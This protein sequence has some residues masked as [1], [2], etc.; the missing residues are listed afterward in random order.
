MIRFILFITTAFFAFSTHA[1]DC[2]QF[3]VVKGKVSFKKKSKSKF[4]KARINKKV[5]QG[6]VV[7]TG[8][9]SRAKIIMADTNEINI[10]PKTEL[11]IE[12]YQKNKKAVLNVLNGKVRSNVKRKYK[13]NANSHYR[14]KTKSAVAGVRGTEFLASYNSATNQSRVVTFEGEVMVGRIDAS[15]AVGNRVSV[16]PGQFITNSVG[17]DPHPP[18]EVPKAELARMDQDSNL[19]EVPDRGNASD[20]KPANENTTDDKKSDADAKPSEEPKAEKNEPKADSEAKEQNRDS[21]KKEERQAK[22]ERREQAKEER[23][24]RREAQREEKRERRE[25]AKEE[26]QQRREAQRE[27]KQERR[28]ARREARQERREARRDRRQQRRGSNGNGR[29]I[30]SVGPRDAAG[31]IPVVDSPDTAGGTSADLPVSDP[32]ALLPPPTLD[33][34]IGN[35]SDTDIRP[36]TIFVPP[37]VPIDNICQTCND[38]VINQKVRVTIRPCVA[39]TCNN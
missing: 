36:P 35:I 23:R 8:P 12:V 24:E 6:D 26:R 37:Q 2:G 4:K 1:A 17:T 31:A 34:G 19:G 38:V 29:G 9:D 22:R 5:C 20:N 15:G 33:G 16:R 13:D 27:A 21:A 14:V 7:K 3:K 39:G 30:A 11:L 28:E 18:K 10:S 32:T 25:Q